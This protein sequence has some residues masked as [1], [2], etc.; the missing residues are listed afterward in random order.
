VSED[1]AAPPPEPGP[2]DEFDEQR[3]LSWVGGTQNG[4]WVIPIGVPSPM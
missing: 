4:S 1:H 3:S 2:F